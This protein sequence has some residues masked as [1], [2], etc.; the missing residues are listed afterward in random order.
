[1][2]GCGSIKRAADMQTGPIED[3]RVKHGRSDIL[4]AEQLLHGSNVVSVFQQMRRKAVSESLAAG[5]LFY[6]RSANRQLHCVLQIFF[7]NVMT[8]HFA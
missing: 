4:V 7:G 2:A 6:T 8:S 5:C 3:V 1:M